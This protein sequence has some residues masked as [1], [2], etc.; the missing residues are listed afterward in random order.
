MRP[1]PGSLGHPQTCQLSR[2]GWLGS[3]HPE[4]LGGLRNRERVGRGQRRHGVVLVLAQVQHVLRRAAV[5]WSPAYPVTKL[6]Q[7]P[8]VCSAVHAWPEGSAARLCFPGCQHHMEGRFGATRCTAQEAFGLWTSRGR[9]SGCGDSDTD[10]LHT[11]G[12]TSGQ[13][14]T[15]LAGERAAH[16]KPA[17]AKYVSAAIQEP[18][19]SR[20]PQDIRIKSSNMLQMSLL[21]WWMVHTICARHGNPH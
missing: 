19:Y 4:A 9:H 20:R 16:L 11:C 10:I 12:H 6:I 21:G 3:A 18:Q 13:L 2:T 7:C 8:R 14:H 17:S 15:G 5:L 1:A